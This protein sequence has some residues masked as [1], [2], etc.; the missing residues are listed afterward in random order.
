MTTKSTSLRVVGV[1][2][3][4]WNLIG[5]AMFWIQM[6]LTPEQ[7]AQFT[8][9]QR[10]VYEATPGW[11]NIVY[12]VAV[13][14]GVFGAIGLLL[15]RRWAVPLFLL[16]LLAVLVQ[17]AGAFTLTPAWSAYGV[18]GLV[19]PAIVLLVALL[20]WRYAHR[21]AARGALG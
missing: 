17:V 18:A 3:L 5:V 4:A 15:R 8:E 2:A 13:L 11:L 9:A 21:A 20:L 6:N 10:Q 1:L 19:M 16:S 12:G 7:L 14:A